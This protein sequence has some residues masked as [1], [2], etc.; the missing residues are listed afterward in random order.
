[1]TE[2]RPGPWSYNPI[3]A[4]KESIRYGK[5]GKSQRQSLAKK[6]LPGPA[7]YDIKDEKRKS[8]KGV[9]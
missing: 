7:D 4:L 3:E 9:M 8:V 1:M 5:I 2:K 6:G